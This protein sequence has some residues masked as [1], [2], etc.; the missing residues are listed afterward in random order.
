MMSFC[1]LGL[2]IFGDSVSFDLVADV[3]EQ[4]ILKL[5][6][7]KESIRLV[8]SMGAFHQPECLKLTLTTNKSAAFEVRLFTLNDLYKGVEGHF[9]LVGPSETE[10]VP[11]YL[12][13]PHK[14]KLRVGDVVLSNNRLGVPISEEVLLDFW[15]EQDQLP[16][17][18]SG[19][20]KCELLAVYKEVN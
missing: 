6:G 17:V 7:P 15:I 14:K 19:L 3:A 20:H 10:K 8:D 5:E 12:L 16:L 11:F 18:D 13:D 1:V 2:V 4:T 9:L